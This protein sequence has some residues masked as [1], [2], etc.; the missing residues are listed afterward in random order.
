M[1]LLKVSI[2]LLKFDLILLFKVYV[3]KVVKEI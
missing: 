3:V 2:F 1:V